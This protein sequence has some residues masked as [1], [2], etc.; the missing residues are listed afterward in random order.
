MFDFFVNSQYLYY[1]KEFESFKNDMDVA[2]RIKQPGETYHNNI[3]LMFKICC[4]KGPFVI[5]RREF[6]DG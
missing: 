6:G 3:F 2:Q 1:S 4:K 5:H